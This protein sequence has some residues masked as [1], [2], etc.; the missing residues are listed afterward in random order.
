MIKGQEYAVALILKK[1]LFPLRAGK[2]TITPLEAEATTLQSAFYAGA[3]A[4]RRSP[5]ITVEV[6]PLPAQGRPPGF[7]AHNVGQLQLEASVDRARVKAG[8]AVTLKVLVR[9]TG[10]LRSVKPPRVDVD[11]FKVYE[12]T[13]R[14][15]IERGDVIRG[16]KTF[17]YL[18][19]PLRGGALTI[20]ALELPYFDPKQAK[21]DVARAAPIAL[22]VEGDPT[23]VGAQSGAEPHENV[24]GAQLRPIRNRTHAGSR[25]SER[26][27]RG[28]LR[29]LLLLTPPTA[30]V[31]VLV[32]DGLRR[33]LT[34]ET[35][36]SKRRRARRT[37]RKRLRAAEYHIKAGRPS[38]FFTECARVI[39]EHLEYRLGQKVEALTLA[40]LRTHLESRGFE[41]ETVEAI[42][43]ELESCDFSRFAPSASGPG[44][45]R[46]ALRR[47][48]TLLGWIEKARTDEKEVAA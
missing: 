24:L 45:M 44:E 20:P 46:A 28:R 42:V 1:A 43:K 32:V 4:V 14:E 36:R 17:T 30:W 10:N 40:E 48:R 9:G 13:T 3:S 2:L 11:G 34:R 5:P 27:W 21:Y 7:D 12:P 23:K 26:V 41:K 8:E 35:A 6:L 37:A 22:T 47:T 25:I 31:L 19:M 29:W 16:D 18:L 33:R 15:N 39:Y 38:A